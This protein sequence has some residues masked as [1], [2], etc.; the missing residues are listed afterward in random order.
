M[1]LAPYV[2]RLRTDLAEAAA[3]GG[4][5]AQE[6]AERLA[7]ALDPAARMVLLE[8][9]SDA[10]AEITTE[11]DDASIEVRLRGREP[12][13][14]IE[15]LQVD[16]AH[17]PDTEDVAD[18]A[19]E[20]ESDT[21]ARVTVRIPESLKNR[22]EE[23]AATGSQSLNSWIVQAIRFAARERAINVD[24]DLGSRLFSSGPPGPPGTPSPPGTP[25][26]PGAA[27]AGGRSRTSRR[28]QG[29][30]R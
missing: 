1:E 23:L 21:V 10:S 17:E 3:A 28:F 12:E 6:A 18:E 20:S 8:A 15:R 30:S 2:E 4:P 14:V 25:R 27:G 16:P 9:L 7:L 19:D 13:F 26:P 24:I 11:L 29:W 22:A 5:E